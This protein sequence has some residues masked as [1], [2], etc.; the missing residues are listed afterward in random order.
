MWSLYYHHI[1]AA[2]K[3]GR[4]ISI[5]LD[6]YG[7]KIRKVSRCWPSVSNQTILATRKK[8]FFKNVAP[9]QRNTCYT[10]IYFFVKKFIF[11]KCLYFSEYDIRI[12]LY[13]FWLRKGSPITYVRNW[14]GMGSHPKSVQLCIGWGDVRSL[15]YVRICTMFLEASLSY[16]VLI[17][18]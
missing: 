14:W 5:S 10:A 3:I 1:L 18:L 9:I 8:L 17:Y 4:S 6:M 12:S 15:V 7:F 16:S 11:F 2:G 13:G